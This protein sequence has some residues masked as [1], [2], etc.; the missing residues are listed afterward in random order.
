MDQTKVGSLIRTLRQQ[1]GM[2]QL[3]LAN[4]LG[5]S[6]KAV[7]KWERGLGCPDV[8]LCPPC[9]GRFKWICKAC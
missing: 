4:Q 3:A 9:P 1:Q 2:A 6:D 8:E 7:S 5:V